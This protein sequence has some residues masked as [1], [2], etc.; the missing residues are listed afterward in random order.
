MS[1]ITNV[2]LVTTSGR[3]SY[4]Q[5]LNAAWADHL[6]PR[7]ADDPRSYHCLRA[8]VGQAWDTRW[9]GT[10][11][12]WPWNGTAPAATFSRNFPTVRLYRGDIHELDVPLALKLSKLA[13]GELDVLDGSPPCQGFSTAG[14]RIL[15]D[16]RNNLFKEFVRLL[17]G[18][19]PKAFVMENVSGMVKGKMRLVFVEILAG[20]QSRRLSRSSASS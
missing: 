9:P 16:P 1:S 3:A 10:G 14:N 13:P 12:C 11:K 17:E 2:P 18:F 5:I 4:P 20:T 15:D 8:A 19:Q 7:D 6:A